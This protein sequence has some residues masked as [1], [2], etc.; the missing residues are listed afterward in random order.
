MS[1]TRTFS[2]KSPSQVYKCLDDF[3]ELIKKENADVVLLQEVD[4]SSVWSYGIEFM[5]YIAEKQGWDIMHTAQSM[6]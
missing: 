5:P 6:T 1:L 4:K 2:I 3:A